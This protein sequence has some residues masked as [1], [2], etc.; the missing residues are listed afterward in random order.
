[1]NN[2]LSIRMKPEELQEFISI[3][4]ECGCNPDTHGFQKDALIEFMHRTR[5][6]N[7]ELKERVGTLTSAKRR[8]LRTMLFEE[9]ERA[10]VF[11]KRK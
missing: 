4:E 11:K 7:N 1:M 8:A 9:F 5:D 6:Y 3:A 10:K 2:I